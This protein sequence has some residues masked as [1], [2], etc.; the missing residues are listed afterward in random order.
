MHHEKSD[1]E[2]NRK[3]VCNPFD[4]E[5][6]DAFESYMNCA[7][8]DCTKRE[9]YLWFRSHQNHSAFRYIGKKNKQNEQLSIRMKAECMAVDLFTLKKPQMKYL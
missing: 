4:I 3:D 6:F 8:L 9:F 2:V 1:H 7:N 5:G